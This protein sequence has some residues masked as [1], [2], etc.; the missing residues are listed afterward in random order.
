MAF[1]R[2][3][4]PSLPTFSPKRAMPYQRKVIKSQKKFLEELFVSDLIDSD[5]N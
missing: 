2:S 4:L 1:I 5:D 3:H